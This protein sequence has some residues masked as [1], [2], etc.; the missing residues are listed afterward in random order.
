MTRN[1]NDDDLY[2]IDALTERFFA[3]FTQSPEKSVDLLPIHDLFVAQGMLIKAVSGST[4]I[5]TLQQFIEPRLRLLNSGELTGFCEQEISARTDIYGNVAQRFS[6]YRKT[7]ILRG[8]S[9]ASSG[10][11]TLQFVRFDSVWKLT[12]VA[13]DD[14]RDASEFPISVTTHDNAV[15]SA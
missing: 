10:T 4:E 6:V 2:A 14:D 13:W 11:K 1:A 8:A 12:C 9:F 7:G 15:A 3:L 5:Y